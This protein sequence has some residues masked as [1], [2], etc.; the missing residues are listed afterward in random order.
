M[1]NYNV[2]NFFND[3]K[4]RK[5]IFNKTNNI[6]K[7]FN[8]HNI[9]LY[10]GFDPTYDSLHIGHLLPISIIYRYYK[11][12]KINFILIGEFTTKIIFNKNKFKFIKNNIKKIKKQI[13]K[14]LNIK[15]IKFINNNY[16]LKK[17]SLYKFL[18][19]ICKYI[20]LNFMLKKKIIYNKL[21]NN[22]SI[23]VTKFLYQL[24]QGYDYY[25]LYKKYKCNLQIGGSDQW[26]NILT[27][28]KIIKKK[29][30]KK[31]HGFT[32]PLLLNNNNI[33][34]SKSN[35]N[36]FNI[37]LNKKYTSV[38]YFYQYFINLS[39]NNSIIY[40]KY[41][42]FLNKINIKTLINEHIKNPEKKILQKQI[43]KELTKWVHN[44]KHC[45]NTIILSNILFKKSFNIKL[46]NKYINII[47]Y[48][49][50]TYYYYFNKINNILIFKFI[51]KKIFFNSNSEY[52][53][54]IKNNGIFLINGIKINNN[55]ITDFN[56]LIKN[57][58]LII[59]KGKKK[60]FLIKF[61]KN[62]NE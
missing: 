41:F 37:W 38:Y 52:K 50:K 59:Q 34:F 16:W 21:N 56:N 36:N 7:Y 9:I 42:S 61:I 62:K 29:Y 27:G 6:T 54:F 44:K 8:N 49:I 18:N 15:N 3:L 45:K 17:L 12:Y 11:I 30:N 5:L 22:N 31:V 1:N 58:Y 25:Y 2:I 60:H 26:S 35:K 55:L 19:N 47:K 33:K 28:I 43:A 14:L 13:L 57:K 10:I 46:I 51:K 20:S 23:K 39:D 4:W 53:K 40:I 24:L 48:Y 32:F